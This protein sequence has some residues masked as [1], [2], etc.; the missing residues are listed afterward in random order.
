MTDRPRPVPDLDWDPKTARA[1]GDDV[2]DLWQELLERIRE[3]PVARRHDHETVR[4]AVVTEIPA[5]PMATDELVQRLREITFEYSMYPGSPGFMAYVSGPGTVPGAVA[6]LLAGGLNQNL[7]G[8]RLSPAGS[9][10]ELDLTR[11]FATKFG[12]SEGAAGIFTSGGAMANFVALKRARDVKAGWDVRRDGVAAGPRMTIYASNEVHNVSDRAADMMGLG[13]GAVRRLPVDDAY[14][15]DIRA[16]RQAIEAD[17]AAGFKPICVVGSAGTVGTGSI[18]PLEEIAAICNEYDLWFHVDGAYGALAMLSDELRPLFPGIELADSIA[19]D[20][21]KWLYTPHSGGCVVVR[22]FQGL[23]DSFSIDASYVHTDKERSG[24][25]DDLRHFGPQF[26]RGFQGLKVWVSLLAHGTDAY[27]RRIAHDVALAKYLRDEAER[28]PDFEVMAPTILSITCFRYVPEDLGD[29]EGR[30]AY[31]SLL[32]ERL[33]TELQ[34]DGRTYCSN[35]V[36]SGA[37]VLR[38]CIVNFRTEAEDIDRLLD[39]CVDIGSKLDRELRPEG[40]KPSG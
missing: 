15:L 7:G 38:A 12:L 20:P 25:G 22:D 35:A 14:R 3:L 21:H 17:L 6:D 11:W 8:W 40:L 18:D 1:F 37:F 2:L 26:S 34:L 39:V 19:F 36:L 4:G 5:Q 10:I 13:D 29:V 27:G 31:L 33:M 9:E 24:F 23:G 16:L 32:N 28:R 30:E